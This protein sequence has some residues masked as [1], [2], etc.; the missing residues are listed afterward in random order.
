MSVDLKV[1]SELTKR[2]T[3]GEKVQPETEQEKLCFKP[4]NDL[5]HVNGHVSGSITQKK[6]MR[7]E[8]WSFILYFEAPHH[9]S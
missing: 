2:M 6:Y 4:I 8:I 1:L 7:N 3:D 5:N 9:G